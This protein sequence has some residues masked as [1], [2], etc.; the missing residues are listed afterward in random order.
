MSSKTIERGSDN[1]FADL[2]FP[3]PD[4]HKL[5]AELVLRMTEIIRAR[6][7]SQTEAGKIIGLSQPDVSRLMRGHV[8]EV[9]TDRL[10]EMLTRLGCE[11]EITLRPPGAADALPVIHLAPAAA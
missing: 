3:D 5:K 1:V 8:R 10:L 7:L 4:T 11:V 6:K 2:G 9:S